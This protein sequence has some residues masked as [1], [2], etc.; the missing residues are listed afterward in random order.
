MSRYQ[1]QPHT[2]I[3]RRLQGG[4]L[5]RTPSQLLRCLLLLIST[6]VPACGAHRLQA[7]YDEGSEIS[8]EYAIKAAYLYQFGRYVEWPAQAFADE[9]APLVIGVLGADPFGNLL[10]EIARTKRI[11]GRPIV[12]RRFTS[13]A[14]CTFCHI[15][16]VCASVDSESKTLIL[17]KVRGNPTLLVGEE[18]GFAERGGTINFFLDENKIRFEINTEVARRDQLKISSKLLSLAKIVS[19]N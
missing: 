7:Q 18:P 14:D 3:A 19:R 6:V 12:I 9:R 17:Q 8:R 2:S 11:E 15:L 13:A 16:F 5:S 4:R 1:Q 10:E